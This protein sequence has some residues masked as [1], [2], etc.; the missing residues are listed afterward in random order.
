MADNKAI[1]SPQIRFSVDKG[2]AGK[3]ER[4]DDSQSGIA[5]SSSGTTNDGDKDTTRGSSQDGA[6]E[7]S[8]RPRMAPNKSRQPHVF[9][10]LKGR[11]KVF[12]SALGLLTRKF[13]DLILVSAC[14]ESY[15]LPTLY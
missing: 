5:G 11:E 2:L 12:G 1:T 14:A 15:V 3:D 6:T 9:V 8:D 10:D 7:P 13:I 4:N